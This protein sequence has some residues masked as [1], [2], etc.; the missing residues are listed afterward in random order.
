M[1]FILFGVLTEEQQN[2]VEQLFREHHIQ[3]Q[4]ISFKIVKSETSA[5]DAVSTAYLKIM[6]N[7]EKISEIPRPQITAFCV[8][9]VK[10]ASVDIIRQSKR[11][12][13]MEAL[14]NLSDESEPSFEDAYIKR[15]DILKL[16]ELI[17]MLT[18]E[19][20]LLIQMKYAQEMGYAEIGALL[21]ISEEAAKKRGQRIIQKL[22]N[23]M[24][25]G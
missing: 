25:R 16:S 13:P 1:F 3:F 24:E 15:S 11:F 10:N 23:Y 5:N 2:L 4:R 21:G 7:I 17:D 6:D 12:V 9:M 18:Q 8:T 20:K 19:D 14:D 22:K